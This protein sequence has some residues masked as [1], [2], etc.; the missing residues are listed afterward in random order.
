MFKANNNIL[1]DCLHVKESGAKVLLIKLLEEL[2]NTKNLI[3]LLDQCIVLDEKLIEKH[4]II[5]LKSSLLHRAY[6]YFKNNNSFCKIFT[7]NNLPPFFNSKTPSYVYF[8]NTL[9]LEKNNHIYSVKQKIILRL[10]KIL[11][12]RLKKNVDFWLVQTTHVSKLLVSAFEVK[13][14]KVMLLPIIP[15]CEYSLNNNYK[16]V[17]NR[18]IYVSTGFE[19]KNH[20]RLIQAFCASHTLHNLGT[21]VLTVDKKFEKLSKFIK[22]KIELGF[23]II[24]LGEVKREKII[25]EYLKSEFVI[26]P[27]LTESFGLGIV[28]G[29]NLGCKLIGANLPYTH[30]IA[31]TNYLFDPYCVDSISEQISKSFF[32][33]QSETLLTVIDKSKFIKYEIEK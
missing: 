15:N 13:L 24:N 22:S 9:L 17:S 8:H 12:I 27:S 26:F 14:D 16:R 33:K 21:L 1:L 31:K 2:V 18:M 30:S 29:L 7:F 4:H 11:I 28:E 25:E 3:I 32:N 5:R 6:F 19:Y 10:K 23:P 20:F